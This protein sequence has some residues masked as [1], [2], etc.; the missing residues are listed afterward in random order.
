MKRNRFGSFVVKDIHILITDDEP[1]IYDLLKEE[2]TELGYTVSVATNGKECLEQI[3]ENKPD[4]LILDIKMPDMSGIEVLQKLKRNKKAKDIYVIM[5]TV[6]TLER[7]IDHVKSLGV[8]AYVCKPS[9]FS[10]ILFEIEKGSN[11]VRKN[12]MRDE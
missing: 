2:L 6:R 12:R 8:D 11:I 5:N 7:E 4:I 3:N 10:S 1:G 9:P